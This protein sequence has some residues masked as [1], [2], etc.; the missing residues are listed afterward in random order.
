MYLPSARAI[1]ILYFHAVPDFARLPGY[2]RVCDLKVQNA[3]FMHL[4]ALYIHLNIQP[5]MHPDMLHKAGV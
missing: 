4:D 2:A 5:F 1:F 3:P